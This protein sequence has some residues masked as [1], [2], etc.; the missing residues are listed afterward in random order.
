MKSL[1][2][3]TLSECQLHRTW[4]Q[5]LP[6][7]LLCCLMHLVIYQGRR[8]GEMHLGMEK[9]DSLPCYPCL[10]NQG[11][12]S[13][14]ASIYLLTSHFIPKGFALVGGLVDD[15]YFGKLGQCLPIVQNQVSP[16]FSKQTKKWIES[17]HCCK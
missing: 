7:L 9:F 6:H 17:S 3:E 16:I 4:G 15:A 2:K 11:W 12:I 1:I 8:W 5:F 10:L 14:I 13:I